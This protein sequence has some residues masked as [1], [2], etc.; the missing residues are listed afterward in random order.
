MTPEECRE[1]LVAA[2]KKLV[3]ALGSQESEKI[4]WASMKAWFKHRITKE[5]FDMECRQLLPKD[6]T[7]FHNEFLLA[8]LTKC[9]SVGVPQS[10]K[11]ASSGLSIKAKKN[12]R[13]LQA[14]KRKFDN[15]FVPASPVD[16]PPAR[17]LHHETK[18]TAYKKPQKSKEPRFPKQITFCEKSLEIPGMLEMNG[19]VAVITWEKGLDDFT[20]EVSQFVIRAIHIFLKNII[21]EICARR[22]CYKI[23]GKNFRHH[24]GCTPQNPYL[25]ADLKLPSLFPKRRKDKFSSSNRPTYDEA[26]QMAIES[27]GRAEQCIPPPKPPANMYDLMLTLQKKKSLIPSHTVYSTSMARII[28]SLWHPDHEEIEQDQKFAKFS[29]NSNTEYR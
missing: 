25:L 7:H 9:H 28:E 21:T 15:R 18:Q 22:S 6:A 5:E 8:V 24:M 11:D 16:L 2:K 23:D 20:D 17:N 19:R 10:S 3:E 13:K 27:M 26:E 29:V 4:Y 1:N 12:K 14:V